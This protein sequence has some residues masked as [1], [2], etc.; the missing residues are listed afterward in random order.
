LVRGAVALLASVCVAASIV[1]TA[2]ATRSTAARYGLKATL[3]TKQEIPAPK[4]AHGA[5]GVLTAKL[6][7]AGKR[8]RFTWR[9]KFSHLSGRAVSAELHFGKVGRTGGVA[10]SLCRPCLVGASGAYKGAYLASAAFR[11]PVLHG[12]LYVTISTKLNP[13]GEIRG[14][15]KATRL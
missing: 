5:T 14:Q 4:D 15:I 3:T 1:A 10:L 8:S 7:L 11:K 13:K 2:G 6:T 12:A 9:L